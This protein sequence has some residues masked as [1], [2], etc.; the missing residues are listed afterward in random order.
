MLGEETEEES[1]C[2][3]NDEMAIGNAVIENKVSPV[4]AFLE[5]YQRF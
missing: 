3:E 5:K 2:A 1:T 4:E